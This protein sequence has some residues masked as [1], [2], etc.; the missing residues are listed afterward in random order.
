M[1]L[2]NIVYFLLI[3]LPLL[4]IGNVNTS[5]SGILSNVVQVSAGYYHTC[6]LLS[7]GQ[8]ACWG[9]NWFG[10]LGVGYAITEPPYGIPYPVLVLGIDGE[11]ILSDVVQI[12]AGGDHTCVLLS[13]GQVACW[14]WNWFGQ[15]G[16]G[17]EI[18]RYIP[19]LVLGINGEGILSDVVQISTGGDHTCAILSSGSVVCW[20]GNWAGQ[21]GVGYATTKEPF[22]IPYPVLVL[23]I[24]GEGTLTDVIQIAT[25]Y[26]HT[27]ALLSNGSVACWGWNYFGQLGTG[28]YEDKYVPTL[29]KGI[30]GEGLLTDV[31]QISA[32]FHHTCALL[33]N[34]Q[35]ACWGDNSVGQ[36]GTGDTNNR[37]VPTL[38]KGINGEG[39]LTDVVQISAGGYHTCALLSNG[40]VACWGQNWHG[41]L[42]TGDTNNRL[43]PTLVKGIN[44]EGILT[45]VIEISVGHYHT[46]ALLSNGQVAC[47]GWNRFGQLG[48][49]DTI[50]RY[51]PT[52]V[53]GFELPGLLMYKLIYKIIP[54]PHYVILTLPEQFTADRI[55]TIYGIT[56]DGDIIVLSKKDILYLDDKN[57]VV[58][59]NTPL[60]YIHILIL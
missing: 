40:S 15:L 29:V 53:V 52:L 17:D 60:Q 6:A 18:N 4:F 54:I 55:I 24:D 39:I 1:R 12:S 47:W 35:V 50:D 13:N 30:N 56:L 44:G 38:V 20:G 42:G 9:Y 34:G 23:G 22:G 26:A 31:I 19:T 11:G 5:S 25:G 2:K 3:L 8:V 16:T 58:R 51:V 33:S 57:I 32:G 48:T 7:N 37:L 14:G 43:V 46:C 10:Q 59:V 21:L 45:N 36:L 49:N 28:D 27:C 41:Q